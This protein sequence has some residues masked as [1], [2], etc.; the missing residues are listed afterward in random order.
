ML[1]QLAH[2][3]D[4]ALAESNATPTAKDTKMMK[5]KQKSGVKTKDDGKESRPIKEISKAKSTKKTATPEKA[6]A[7]KKK[8]TIPAAAAME[9]DDDEEEEEEE[10]VF[11]GMAKRAGKPADQS[12]Q[13]KKA[14]KENSTPKKASTK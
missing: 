8:D 11:A 5:K 3:I 1:D 9:V 4:P 2:L 12:R 14:R 10:S 13:K 6:K 7:T